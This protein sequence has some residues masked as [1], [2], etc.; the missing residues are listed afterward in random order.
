MAMSRSGGAKSV[1]SR[2]PIVI[3]PS[4]TSSRPAI[5]PQHRRLTAPRRADEHH[6][7]PI[8]DVQRQT[9]HGR[10]P[11]G[12]TFVQRS[13]VIAPISISQL[14]SLAMR[15]P[16]CGRCPQQASRSCRRAAVGKPQCS[17]FCLIS[18]T[19]SPTSIRI[20]PL[21]VPTSR[22]RLSQTLLA[23]Q[24]EYPDCKRL[25]RRTSE[26]QHVGTEHG[27]L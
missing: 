20:M 14:N 24:L 15:E 7:L 13:R 12:Y 9:V 3:V 26:G 18:P 1:T 11:L 27:R 6:E 10:T 25:H 16:H 23:V 2:S 17:P 4:V 8:V 19:D 5:I 21:T 22:R